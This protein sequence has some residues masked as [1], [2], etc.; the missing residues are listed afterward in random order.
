MTPHPE[1][2]HWLIFAKPGQEKE[3]QVIQLRGAGNKRLSGL[4]MPFGEFCDSA[5][6]LSSFA[7][8]DTTVT[9]GLPV[10]SAPNAP[11][12]QDHWVAL[13]EHPRRILSAPHLAIHNDWIETCKRM[14]KQPRVIACKSPEDALDSN[15][16]LVRM[17][18]TEYAALLQCLGGE[19]PGNLGKTL[20][21]HAQW[22]LRPNP[23]Y[24]P[25]RLAMAAM[26]MATI[27]CMVAADY[28]LQNHAASNALKHSKM[29]SATSPKSP[30]NNQASKVDWQAWI[31]QL[32]KL[33]KDDRANIRSLTWAWTEHGAVHTQVT[34]ERP[35]KKLPKGCV[36]SNDNV[37]AVCTPIQP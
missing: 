18:G 2:E 25:F 35:R 34:L 5:V 17:C 23:A 29:A 8:A 33:G 36:M 21:L 16:T 32:Q 28:L 13:A 4:R 19:E 20:R 6:A 31:V 22:Y 7:Q 30:G 3:A 37:H 14:G 26:L 24:Q 11:D 9:L 27:V 12:Q 15:H 10:T 1:A